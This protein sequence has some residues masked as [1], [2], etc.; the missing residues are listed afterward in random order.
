MPP[1]P[2]TSPDGRSFI[3]SYWAD[4]G[5]NNAPKPPRD[6]REKFHRRTVCLQIRGF[7]GRVNTANL[8][9]TQ[10]HTAPDPCFGGVLAYYVSQGRAWEYRAEC[11]ENKKAQ[12]RGGG[13]WACRASVVA[14]TRLQMSMNTSTDSIPFILLT[15]Q[16]SHR[17][18]RRNPF[19]PD[20]LPSVPPRSLDAH[21]RGH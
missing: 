20:S 2:E 5:V 15:S 10:R 3:L 21:L 6:P 9:G 11:G 8:S 16:L 7:F 19:R 18:T 14:V 17:G 4:S 12:T 13:V 1:Y